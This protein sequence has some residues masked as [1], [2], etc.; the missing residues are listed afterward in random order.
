MEPRRLNKTG[1]AWI[2]VGALILISMV[3]AG[4][5]FGYSVLD[6]LLVR[7]IAMVSTAGWGYALIV[8]GAWVLVQSWLFP[9]DPKDGEV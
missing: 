9:N 5:L 8:F 2:A 6:V 3:P 7:D 1:W 4:L